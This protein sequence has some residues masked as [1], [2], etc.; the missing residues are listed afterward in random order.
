[1]KVALIQ[2]AFAQVM[3]GIFHL[4]PLFTVTLFRSGTLPYFAFLSGY[5][6]FT[7]MLVLL[8]TYA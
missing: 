4:M 1:M 2:S 3:L 7:F 6:R 5:I 8:K